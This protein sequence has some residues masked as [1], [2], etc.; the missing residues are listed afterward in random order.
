MLLAKHDLKFHQ[1]AT[2]SAFNL[3]FL[4]HS[5]VQCPLASPTNQLCESLSDGK[6]FLPVHFNFAYILMSLSVFIN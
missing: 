4:F 2:L 1:L 5:L 6:V 3:A